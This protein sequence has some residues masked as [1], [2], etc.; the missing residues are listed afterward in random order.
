MDQK[1]DNKMVI[2]QKNQTDSEQGPYKRVTLSGSKL[3]DTPV[4]LKV[5]IFFQNAHS[6]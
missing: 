5:V 6:T 4:C 1:S 3:C 2:L